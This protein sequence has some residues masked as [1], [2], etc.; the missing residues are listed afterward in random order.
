M[1]NNLKGKKLNRNLKVE[2]LPEGK[3]GSGYMITIEGQSFLKNTV[4]QISKSDIE[5]RPREIKE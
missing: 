2:E 5:L 1:K 4:K 3:I